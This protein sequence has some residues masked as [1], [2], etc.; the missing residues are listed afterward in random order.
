MQATRPLCSIL[1][2]L[3]TSHLLVA[4]SGTFVLAGNMTIPRVQHGAALLQ[5]GKVLIAGGVSNYA[6]V[7][8]AEIYDPAAKTFTPTGSMLQMRSFCEMADPPITL[9]NGTVLAAGG[10]NDNG[11][12]SE[13]ELY[14]PASGSF[15]LTGS[16]ST[17]RECPTTTLLPSGLVLIA[18]GYSTQKNAYQSSAELYNPGTGTFS[19]AGSMHHARDGAAAA[20]LQD[21]RVLIAGGW[22]TSGQ[23]TSAEIYDPASNRFTDT[24]S[25]R[26]ARGVP[27]LG[28][29]TLQNGKVL[30]TGYGFGTPTEIY[31]PATGRFSLSASEAFPDV[32]DVDILLNNGKVLIV[33]GASY[34]STPTGGTFTRAFMSFSAYPTAIRLA[35]GSVLVC[36]GLNAAPY[37]DNAGIYTP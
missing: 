1:L 30:R 8:S 22:D 29:T 25:M 31:D 7:S 32:G 16:M 37:S 20:V 28:L 15:S 19:T 34:L 21:G 11:A 13:A 36:G 6:Y 24:G 23:L 10:Y 26:V 4:Q 27:F 3:A 14:D 5:D 9:A 18:G 12:L 33:G 35:D 17:D 2:F